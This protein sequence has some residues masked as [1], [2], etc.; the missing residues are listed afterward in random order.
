VKKSQLRNIIR[1][2]IKG[3]ITENQ[4]C[5]IPLQLDNFT[6]GIN[7]NVPCVQ[8][9][10]SVWYNGS[11]IRNKSW[12][13]NFALPK[14]CGDYNWAANKL[15]QKAQDIMSQFAPNTPTTQTS[16]SYMD[17]HNAANEGFGVGSSSAQYQPY[18]FKFIRNMILGKYAQ[19][20]KQSCGC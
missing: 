20:M 18:K 15:E 6:G 5:N 2:S 3:L 8:Q 11:A 1:E 12:F 17:I 7:Q 16:N 14:Q 9:W 4:G 13:I 19:C 10:A